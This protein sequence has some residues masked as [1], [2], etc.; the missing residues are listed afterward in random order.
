MN[1]RLTCFRAA[2][3][4]QKLTTPGTCE[5]AGVPFV[6][7][8]LSLWVVQNAGAEVRTRIMEIFYAVLFGLMAF[9]AAILELGKPREASDSNLTRDFLRFSRCYCYV[10]ERGFQASGAH[11]VCFYSTSTCTAVQKLHNRLCP[12][13]G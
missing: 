10:A 8:A 3:R 1:R 5:Y 6:F 11:I 4:T 9:A 2:P 7:R 12:D 13:D